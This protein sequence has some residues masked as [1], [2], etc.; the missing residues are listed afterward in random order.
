MT[1]SLSAVLPV[2]A[3]PYLLRARRPVN[4]VSMNITA[5]FQNFVKKGF[6]I[7]SCGSLLLLAF[8]G[9]AANFTVT[10]SGFQ[11]VP[12]SITISV[13]DTIT[14]NNLFSHTVTGDSVAEPF[15]G[16]GFPGASCSVT[17]NAAGSFSYR[18]IPHAGFGMAGSVTVNAAGVAP[19][20]AITNPPNNALFS[21]PAA[22]TIGVQATDADGSVASV[23][24][25]TNGV[26]GV[27]DSAAPFSFSLSNLAQGTYTLRARAT[28]NQALSATSAP[29]NIRVVNRPALSFT[30]GSNGPVEL[31]FTTVAGVSYVIEQSAVLTNFSAIVT[32]P[33]NG[34]TL[35][36]SETNGAGGQGFYRVR[37]E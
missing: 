28:D 32:N 12:S 13:G 11:F 29:V 19:S 34:G 22:V 26:A 6:S 3:N 9:S 10:T 31:Q 17:F 8:S 16:S 21:A 27:T 18:C 33:G 23:Q 14:W 7:L 36:Y 15:C 25:L 1:T 4:V 2:G 5:S 35:H 20:V 37:L 24:L 30:R